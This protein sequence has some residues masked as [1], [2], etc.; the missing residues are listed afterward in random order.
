MRGEASSPP[1]RVL[2]ADDHYLVREGTRT[3]LNDE[4]D[5]QVVG[6]AKDGREAVELCRSLRPDLVLMDVRMPGMDG[7][8]ATRAI[9]GCCPRTAVLVVTV[10][11]DPDHLLEA[12]RAGAAGYVLKE[13]GKSQLVGAVRGVLSGES[14]LDQ[15][16]TMRLL[17]RVAAE[18]AARR[19][20][21]GTG[22]GSEATAKNEPQQSPPESLKS[23]LSARELEVLRLIVAGRTNREIARELLI[24]LSTVKDHVQRIIAKLRVSDR[25]Q[26]AVRATELGLLPE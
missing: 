6:E 26:A 20:E 14:Q 21:V 8:A 4:P 5:L 23:L 25:T 17:R 10:E 16:L 13:S 11:D 3:M 1:A 2:I 22:S 18:G 9:K 7:L 15:G 24:G 19:Q 12:V